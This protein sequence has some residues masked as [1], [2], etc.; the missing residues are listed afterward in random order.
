MIEIEQGT[1]QRNP[2]FGDIFK[3]CLSLQSVQTDYLRL[4]EQISTSLLPPYPKDK[5]EET[6]GPST[7]GALA[8]L[9]CS[10]GQIVDMAH[11]TKHNLQ[12]LNES[13][14]VKETPQ[15]PR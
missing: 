9:Y 11:E 12:R 13:L 8:E 10:L 1:T 4:T 6:T 5:K 7:Q 15:V 3:I 2:R 14:S